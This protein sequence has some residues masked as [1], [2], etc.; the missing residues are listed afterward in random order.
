MFT[1]VPPDGGW[2]W[3]IVLAASLN[4]LST[5]PIIQGFGLIF[6]D[7]FNT[8]NLTATDTSVIINVNL[9]FGMILGLINGPLLKIFGYR[10]VAMTGSILFAV[11]VTLTAFANSFTLIIICYGIL[12]SI[13]MS[14]S[15]SGFSLATNSYFTKKKTRTSCRHGND[16]HST[17]SNSYASNSNHLTY[18]LWYSGD[19]LD[20]WRLQFSLDDWCHVATTN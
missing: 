19:R 11:G 5:I 12:T 4:G 16:S 7:F 6:K 15:M 10:K 20:T 3:I 8:L 1:K 17:W 14:M 18:I 13:G 2:G 9:A